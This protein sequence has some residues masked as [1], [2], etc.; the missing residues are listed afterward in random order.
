[1]GSR[2]EDGR[3]PRVTGEEGRREGEGASELLEASCQQPR[4]RAAWGSS[5]GQTGCWTPQY[6][7]SG[8]GRRSWLY[9]GDIRVCVLCVS[10]KVRSRELRL[11]M[12]Q[13]TAWLSKTR[14]RPSGRTNNCT[15]DGAKYLFLHSAVAFA[16]KK[17]VSDSYP[18]LF[19][20][21]FSSFSWVSTATVSLRSPRLLLQK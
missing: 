14:K 10:G 6:Q 13:K 18:A 4:A 8:R 3:A 17:E 15:K 19:W 9:L 16:R 21:V 1:M 12:S 2:A 11:P 20:R 5:Q 7:H